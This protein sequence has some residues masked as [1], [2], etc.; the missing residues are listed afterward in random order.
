LQPNGIKTCPVNVSAL[1][2]FLA[3]FIDRIMAKTFRET[4]LEIRVTLVLLD[5]ARAVAERDGRTL[6]DWVRKLVLDAIE[7]DER[8]RRK[9]AA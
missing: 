6:S 4:R 9:E 1:K 3:V 8:E 5:D 7:A 2:N